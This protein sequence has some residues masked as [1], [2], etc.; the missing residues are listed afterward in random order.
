MMDGKIAKVNGRVETKSEHFLIYLNSMMNYLDIDGL[1]VY[2]LVM[3][4]VHIYKPAA[5]RELLEGRRYKRVYCRNILPFSIS[6]R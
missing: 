2:Y 5:I 1:R 6:L 4:N 3:D